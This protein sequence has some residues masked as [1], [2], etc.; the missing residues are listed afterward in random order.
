MRVLEADLTYVNGVFQRGIGVEVDDATGTIAR[1][2]PADGLGGERF[3]LRDRALLP[4]F[5]N[6]HSHSF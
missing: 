4:G 6:A 5:V 1:V 3:R 2:G